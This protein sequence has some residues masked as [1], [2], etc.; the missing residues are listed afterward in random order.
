VTVRRVEPQPPASGHLSTQA[1]KGSRV[2]SNDTRAS[3]LWGNSESLAVEGALVTPGAVGM[4]TLRKAMTS[5]ALAGNERTPAEEGLMQRFQQCAGES[6]TTAWA[7]ILALCK[8]GAGDGPTGCSA[9]RS[10][11]FGA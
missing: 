1:Q 6:S 3:A 10:A 9:G 4:I 2:A 11:P 7:T 5:T 8:A